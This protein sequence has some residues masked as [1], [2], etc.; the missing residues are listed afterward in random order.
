DRGTRDRRFRAPAA[1]PAAAARLARAGLEPAVGNVVLGQPAQRHPRRPGRHAAAPAASGGGWSAVASGGPAG[2]PRPL[3]D[4]PGALRCTGGLA[5]GA[6]A[7]DR[8][9][10][11]HHRAAAH[12][13]RPAADHPDRVAD[14][15]A[16]LDGDRAGP[17]APDHRA[18]HPAR[19]EPGR[20]RP[21]ARRRA[22]G[23]GA[24][25][26][27]LR[28]AGRDRRAGSGARRERPGIG[29]EDAV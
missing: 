10:R 22:C 28:F 21:S 6:P 7:W 13:L 29:T 17:G 27:G 12:R 26:A 24:R 23:G 3:R 11:H 1:A 2:V 18:A 19:R 8:P 15:G 14:P 4:R 25:G 20:R 9:E 5:D 16:G